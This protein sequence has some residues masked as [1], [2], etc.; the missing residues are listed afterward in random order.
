VFGNIILYLHKVTV[1]FVY[2]SPYQDPLGYVVV[3]G[4]GVFVV[5]VVVVVVIVVVVVVVVMRVKFCE[6]YIFP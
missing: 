1:R 5:V 4:G 2:T 3:G 6:L